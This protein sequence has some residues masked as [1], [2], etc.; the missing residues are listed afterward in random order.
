VRFEMTRQKHLKTRVR[1]RM[2][3]TGERY[4][5]ARARVA[6]TDGQPAATDRRVAGV[7]HLEGSNPATT[8]LRIAFAA[9][10]VRDPSDRL[11]SE[12][13][14]LVLGGGLGAGVFA[15][16]YQKADVSTLFLAGRHRWDDD[17]AF[18]E[19]AARR[20]GLGPVVSETGSRA[21]ATRNLQDALGHGPA[22]VWVDLAVLG[23]RGLPPTWE[24]GGYHVIVV[25]EIDDAAGVAVIG[26]VAR[27]PIPVPVDRLAEAR[28]RIAKQRNRT[29]TI[30]G[31]SA[32]DLTDAIRD[33]LRDGVDALA[34]PRRRNF[35]L[36]AFADL[37]DRMPGTGRD[38]WARAFPRGRHLYE[39]LRSLYRF[40]DGY[41]SGGGLMRPLFAAG[42]TE[43]AS[44]T[45]DPGLQDVATRYAALGRAWSDLAAAALPASVPLL[46]ETREILA[47]QELTYRVRGVEALPALRAGWQRLTAIETAVAERFPLT[48]RETADL[49]AGLAE[50]LRRIYRD[51]VDALA[52]LRAAVL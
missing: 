4:A 2:E 42:L 20:L 15:F 50:R 18:I 21:T 46:D 5:V 41:G 47:E 51:E 31:G 23:T 36:E 24:G 11:L 38:S 32:R 33:G 48:E 27:D 49:V 37:A 10:G 34:G 25:Y 26:D 6:G 14:T 44:I 13:L 17:L 29:L 35:G 39:A 19:G 40:V 8:A 12:G 3:R 16:H 30:E 1:A 9:A 43:A 45:G 28:A 22:I 52:A 7:A